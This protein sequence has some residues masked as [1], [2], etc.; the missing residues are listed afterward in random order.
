MWEAG[1][2]KLRLYGACCYPQHRVHNEFENAEIM[3]KGVR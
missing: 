2:F 3:G 1:A